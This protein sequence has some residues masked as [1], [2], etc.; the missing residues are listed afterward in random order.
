MGSALASV[1]YS[2]VAAGQRVVHLATPVAGFP[3]TVIIR[4]Q[5][6]SNLDDTVMEHHSIGLQALLHVP[7]AGQTDEPDAFALL[8]VVIEHNQFDALS[9]QFLCAV[10]YK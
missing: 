1:A 4:R 2:G 10:A 7:L 9:C 5:D 6:T 8:G 3:L